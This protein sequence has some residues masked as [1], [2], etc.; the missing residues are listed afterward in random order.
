MKFRLVALVPALAVDD[1]LQRLA[2]H[3]PAQVRQQHRG[4]RI[5][6]RH[7]GDV[8]RNQYSGM[9]PQ[10]MVFRQGLRICDVEDGAR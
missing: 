9:A 8:R 10:R 7:A 2:G 4:R 3:V 5:G 1:V 6:L